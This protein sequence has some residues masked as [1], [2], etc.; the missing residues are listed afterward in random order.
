MKKAKLETAT[1]AAGCF[2]GVEETFRTTKGVKE[3]VVGYTGGHTKNPTYKDVCSD[4]TGHAEAVQVTFDPSEVS[5]EDLL[6]VFWDNHDPTQYHRQGP[7]VGSQYRSVIFYHS[8]KQKK[9]AEDSKKFWNGSGK[10]DKPIVT[11]IEPAKE[12]YKAEE[13]HQKYLMKGGMSSC[14]I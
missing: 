13:Y 12:F 4:R 10:F 1:F 6:N 14:H 9:L 8:P 2:W 5:Y 7:D 11:N 3:T